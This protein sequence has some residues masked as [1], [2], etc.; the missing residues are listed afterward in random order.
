MKIRLKVNNAW[1]M[2]F[3]IF[4]LS[5][6]TLLIITEFRFLKEIVTGY[7]ESLRQV[8]VN[9]TGFFLDDLRAVTEGAARRLAARG[10]D[11][12][13]ALKEVI[14]LDHRITA[15]YILDSRGRVVMQ[16]GDAHPEDHL[17][18]ERAWEERVPRGTWMAGVSTDN[19]A[20]AVLTVVTPLAGEWL[21]V[22][23][24]LTG[25]QQEL[26]QEFMGGASK[27]AVFDSNN[28]PVVW[29]FGQE[30][31]DRFTGRENKFFA[32]QLRYDVGSSEVGQPP[33]KLYF[34]MRENNFDTYRVITVMF[35]LFAL[36]C[37][38]YQLL[39]ELWGVNSANSYFENID[40]NIFNYLHEG[41]IISNNAG[42]V[43]FANKSAHDIF[44]FRTGLL[45]GIKLKE[46]LGHIGDAPNGQNSYGALTLKAA[47]RLLQAVHSPIIKNGKVLGALTVV[48]LDGKVEEICGKALS[49]LMDAL[50]QGVVF[51]DRNHKVVQAG[52]MARYY[53]GVLD[54]GMSV[55]AVDPELASFIYR[56][57]GS[58][59]VKRVRLTSLNL[60]CEVIFIY[61]EG[62]AHAGTLVLA[63]QPDE[64][65]AGRGGG[66]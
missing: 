46:I 20:R 36:Y 6:I 18:P 39:V 25:F 1:L 5:V 63:S 16:S 21:A 13:T 17:P 32:G 34:F 60:T 9:K 35:L 26:T 4:F 23:Y 29:P 28:Y 64:D 27:V 8:A 15:V 14:S 40:F 48:G 58:R 56:N 54:S 47:G 22:D 49:R 43:I 51:L 42:R 37:C 62:G 59:S 41:V 50:P 65:G 12:E 10:E 53:L 45:K 3:A 2:F 31:L 44:A 38:L 11:R 30:M 24:S 7:Q 19:S 61:D 66:K 33:W 52:L 55:D 57:M